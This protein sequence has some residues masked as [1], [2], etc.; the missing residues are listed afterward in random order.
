M[1]KI[2]LAFASLLLL[3]VLAG[4][5]GYFWFLS[6]N[7]VNEGTIEV[8]KGSTVK[9]IAELLE[10]NGVIPD[11]NVFYYYIRVKQ[12]YYDEVK[13][14]P[15]AY[16]VTF[17]HGTYDIAPGDFDSLIKFLNEAEGAVE[18]TVTVTIP[19]GVTLDEIA[20][21]FGKSGLFTKEAFLEVAQD[22]AVYKAFRTSYSWLP[23]IHP[24]R[25]VLFEGYLHPNTYQLYLTST[26]KD[27]IRT[28]L[29]KTNAIYTAHQADVDAQRL[30][31]HKILTLASVVERESKFKEDRPKVAQVF[32]NR[33]AKGMKLESDMT[34]A[35]ANGEHKVFMY[36]KDIE[37]KSPYN[38]YHSKGLPI[39]PIASPSESAILSVLQPAGESFRA[40][41]F[42]AR[43]NGETFYA[44]D[45]KQH[46]QNRKKYEHEWKDLEQKEQR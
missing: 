32:L 17:R 37:T 22:P 1:K 10:E 28:M 16:D 7:H 5:G 8:A 45:W 42:Y 46:E 23:E 15:G 11:A 2:L 6:K 25:K 20:E 21:I 34:A 44:D 31:F 24:E 12:M 18:E 26:P 38:T 9:Q 30:P 13:K 41:Y 43:P 29:D 4:V 33:M 27:V 3:V 36:Y 39:G 19:E 14:Q 35:Y 40:L